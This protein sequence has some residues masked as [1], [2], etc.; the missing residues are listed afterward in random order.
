M[1]LIASAPLSS[2][3][4]AFDDAEANG[5]TID[6]RG[7]A[8]PI[9]GRIEIAAAP[10]GRPAL[11]CTL[12]PADTLT[13]FGL[14]SEVNY[15]PEANAERWYC[16]QVYMPLD[17][18]PPTGLQLCF[19][20][21]HDSPDDGESPVKFP[22]FAMYASGGLVY[23]RVPANAPNE[24]NSGSRIPV[25]QPA[26]LVKG[27]WVD[28]ALHTNW[29][30]GATGFLEVWYDG[31]LLHREWSRACGYTD[32]V[33]PYIK[34]GL[35]K[36]FSVETLDTEY[37]CWYSNWRLFGAGETYRSIWG[38]EPRGIDAPVVSGVALSR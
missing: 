33:G 32:A 38:Y 17:F 1:P 18:N 22:N 10:D 30:T 2:V 37:R 34:M 19:M 35:Y 3:V 9:P 29:A 7:I 14:R 26:R 28:V 11:K 31:R 12:N 24:G 8:A 25:G 13:R 4:E 23:C 21:V 6:P 20:Q 27:R 15:E 16:V 36:F 5:I